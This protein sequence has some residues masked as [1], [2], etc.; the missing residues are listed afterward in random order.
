MGR[1]FDRADLD[2]ILA[3][4][5]S[6]V[7]RRVPG[8]AIRQAPDMDFLTIA[9]SRRSIGWG[10]SGEPGIF[11]GGATRQ[12]SGN[13]RQPCTLSIYID[14]VRSFYPYLEWAIDMDFVDAV[15]VYRSGITA[16]PMFMAPGS[17]C[18]T[19]VLWTRR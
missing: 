16:P 18:G 2:A 15:E 8:V 13:G 19:I 5:L 14:G 17:S 12:S 10:L 1:F 4:N 9:Q 7:L 6:D 3:T 11:T